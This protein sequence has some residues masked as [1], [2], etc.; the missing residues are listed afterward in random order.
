M[1]LSVV[2]GAALAFISVTSAHAARVVDQDS[3]EGATPCD[4]VDPNQI[5]STCLLPFGPPATASEAITS[6]ELG[7]ISASQVRIVRPLEG[8]TGRYSVRSVST[9][10]HRWRFMSLRPAGMPLHVDTAIH[11]DAGDQLMLIDPLVEPT[12]A[13][14]D[15]DTPD[16]GSTSQA[17]AGLTVG[18]HPVGRVTFEPD[19][20]GDG[21]GDETEDLCPGIVGWQCAGGSPQVTITG[22]EWFPSGDTASRG[23]TVKNAGVEPQPFVVNLYSRAVHPAFTTPPGAKCA[24]GA[25]LRAIDA[26]VA[27]TVHSPITLPDPTDDPALVQW[28][29]PAYG[30]QFS[31]NQWIHCA[32]PVLAPGES[33]SGT[34]GGTYWYGK[35]ARTDYHAVQALVVAPWVTSA[36]LVDTIATGIGDLYHQEPGEANAGWGATFYK[37][38]ILD[39]RGQTTVEATCH[40]DLRM[41]DCTMTG[42]LRAPVDGQVLGTSVAPVTAH[43]RGLATITFRFSKAGLRWLAKHKARSLD[44]AISSAWPTETTVTSVQRVKPLRTTALRRKLAKLI[45]PKRAKR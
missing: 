37:V 34:I 9:A 6:L 42:E 13:V 41:P 17:V 19:A 28:T 38:P 11:L 43:P 15:F 39:V 24:P 33:V 31:P 20:D 23:W 7:N 44:V 36:S 30:R 2:A 5:D 10:P 4:Q 3:A 35:V 21:F 22:P 8:E 14:V 32:L 18:L 12:G 16:G 29:Q 27:P 26:F 25:T 45:K 40:A 1:R